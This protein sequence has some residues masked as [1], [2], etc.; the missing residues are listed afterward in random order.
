MTQLVIS[1]GITSLVS[2]F[3]GALDDA[4][5]EGTVTSFSTTEVTITTAGAVVTLSGTGFGANGS[6]YFGNL[7]SMSFAFTNGETIDWTDI[8]LLVQDIV[9][10]YDAEENPVTPQIDAVENLLLP[11]AWDITFNDSDDILNSKTTSAD[12]IKLHLTGDNYFDLRGGADDLFASD[13]KDTVF[14]GAGSDTIDGGN[15]NDRLYGEKGDDEIR[16][17]KGRD[18][19]RGG[20]GDDDLSGGK[21]R[22]NLNG[23][24]GNDTLDGGSGDDKLRGSNGADTFVFNSAV[25]SGDSDIIYDY[26]LGT[27]FLILDAS[28]PGSVTITDTLDGAVIAYEDN[29][30]LVIGVTAAQLNEDP[31]L[32]IL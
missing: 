4:F 23:G 18:L 11:L 17:S 8:G 10:A 7:D 2:V 22:D 13:G 3:Y 19:L 16:G 30:I 14:G 25:S 29:Q 24:A 9:A 21:G 20:T 27:D 12:G 26:E 5:L 31:N 15:D 28:D 32:Q 6:G 1:D